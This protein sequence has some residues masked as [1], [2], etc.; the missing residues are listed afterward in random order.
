MALVLQVKKSGST[1]MLLAHVADTQH[2]LWHTLKL[3]H[4]HGLQE[5]SP[6]VLQE[7]RLLVT[8]ESVCTSYLVIQSGLLAHF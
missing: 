1:Q 8:G 2:I 5:W 7:V 6:L 4:S 3:S